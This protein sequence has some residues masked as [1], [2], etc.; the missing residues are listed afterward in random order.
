MPYEYIGG[1]NKKH[2]GILP[3]PEVYY[4]GIYTISSL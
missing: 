1:N 3:N 4:D 2:R